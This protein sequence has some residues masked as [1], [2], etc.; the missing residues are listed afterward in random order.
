MKKRSKIHYIVLQII[1]SGDESFYEKLPK[2]DVPYA[3][4]LHIQFK[5]KDLT[6]L[7]KLFLEERTMFEKKIELF[8][9]FKVD[10]KVIPINQINED[11]VRRINDLISN[12]GDCRVLS[13][14]LQYQ[15]NK[16]IFNFVTADGKDFD[17]NGYDYLKEHFKINYSKDNYIFPKLINLMYK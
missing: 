10:L 12:V 8:L 7:N 5:E 9:K 13:S 17:P 3:K 15:K 2:R 1:K 14:A 11:L 6:E 16:E 4:K